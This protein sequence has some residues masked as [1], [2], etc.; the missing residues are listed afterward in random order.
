MA[1][2][3]GRRCDDVSQRPDAVEPPPDDGPIRAADGCCPG[4]LLVEEC[5]PL[6]PGQVLPERRRSHKCTS[7]SRGRRPALRLDCR[8]QV[9]VRAVVGRN[10]TETQ[11]K[12]RDRRLPSVIERELRGWSGMRLCSGPPAGTHLVLRGPR[13][14]TGLRPDTT[15]P[16]H[17]RLAEAG[18][19]SWSSC[20]CPAT[21]GCRG[22]SRPSWLRRPPGRR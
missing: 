1:R 3:A 14:R 6:Q 13:S 12:V 4:G 16:R 5:A 19:V 8:H 7:S 15:V 21:A 20:P 10:S 11:Q 17:P 18:A 22:P 2:A 9:R